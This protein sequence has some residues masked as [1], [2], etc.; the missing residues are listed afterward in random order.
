MN[1]LLSIYNSSVG[2]KF[3]MALSGL[4]LC[5]FL[6]IHCGI[7]LFLFVG[8]SEYN[9]YSHFMSSN[10]IIRTIEIVLFLGIFGHI[11]TGV[12]LWRRNKSARPQHYEMNSPS[13]NSTFFSRTMFL[14][15]SII[16]FFFVVHLRTFWVP[17][18][19]IGEGNSYQMVK[20]AF[21]SPLYDLLYVVAIIL[22]AFHLRH[23]FQ[24]AFQ[25]FGIKHKKY[26]A[27]IEATGAIFWLLIPLAFAAMPIYFLIGGG[28]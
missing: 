19:F 26:A 24:S 18:R 22:V 23:G 10:P 6:V 28:N 8:E 2:K 16:T 13:A 1:T 14:S 9:L 3:T 21:Q 7:N 20:S 11:I 25:T 4:F 17:T 12:V 5:S 27:L 15:G